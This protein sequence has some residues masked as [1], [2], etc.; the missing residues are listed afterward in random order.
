MAHVL[1]RRTNPRAVMGV[2]EGT[3]FSIPDEERP[4][5]TNLAIVTVLLL[6][7][8]QPC[9]AKKAHAPLPPRLLTAK[10]VCVSSATDEKLRD[11]A[12]QE[13]T[14]TK[15]FTF[16]TDCSA[17]DLVFS[18]EIHN[19]GYVGG[20]STQTVVSH[21][22]PTG[23]IYHGGYTVYEETFS[24]ADAKTGEALWKENGYE[25]KRAVNHLIKQIKEQ[26][27]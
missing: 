2:D 11:K 8:A 5:K 26:E 25:T 1:W 14:K 7:V 17:A 22:T 18:F 3:M 23:K 24:V 13:I 19:E 9:F 16:V 27:Q 20:Y 4:M 6:G 10:T 21:V 15:Y 12:F